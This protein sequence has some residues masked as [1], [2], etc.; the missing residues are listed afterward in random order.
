MRRLSLVLAA[1]IATISIAQAQ[2][3]GSGSDIAPAQART[4]AQLLAEGYEI[5][6]T[7]QASSRYIVFMQKE[8]SAYACQ[9][10]TVTTTRCGLIN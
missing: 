3:A 5:K 2:E 1:L 9:F 7:A 4:M 6:G 10:V 8:K